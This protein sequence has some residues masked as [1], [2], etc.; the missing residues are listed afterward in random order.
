MRVYISST[1]LDLETE[2]RVVMDWLIAQDHQPVHSYVADSET[3]RDSCLA[4]IDRCDLYILLLCHRYGSRPIKNNPENLSITHLEFRRAGDKKIPR[5]ALL[6]TAIPNVV[7]S[8]IGDPSDL[9]A[10][11]KFRDEVCHELRPAEFNDGAS[12]LAGLSNAVGAFLRKNNT[13]AEADTRSTPSDWRWPYAWDFSAYIASKRLNF[14]GR[15]WLFKEIDAWLCNSTP[16]DLLLRADFGVGKTAFASELIRRDRMRGAQDRLVVAIHFCQ[17]DTRET[18]RASTFVRSVAAQLAENV[19]GYKALVESSPTAQQQLDR[20]AEDPGSAFEAAILNPLI[21]MAPFRH[22]AV[23]LVDAIDESLELEAAEAKRGT[24]VQLLADKAP[25]LPTWIRLLVTSRNNPAV[26]DRLKFAFGPKE[27]DGEALLNLDDIRVYVLRRCTTEPIASKLATGDTSAND[28]ADRLCRK[29]GGKFLYAVRVLD[30]LSAGRLSSIELE[31]LPT[32]M[33][34]FY[35]DAFERRF[36]RAGRDYVEVAKLFGI[37]VASREPMSPDLL[38]LVLSIGE[39]KL[40]ALRVEALSDFIR[41]RDGHWVFDHSSL[42]EW[43]C[44]DD[45]EGNA[46]AGRYGVDLVASRAALA[47]WATGIYEAGLDNVHVHVLRHLPG[48]LSDSG[49]AARVQGL[50][51]DL[52]W[53]QIKLSQLGP[54]ELLTDFNFA[55][56]DQTTMLLAKT[57]DMCAHIFVKDPHQLCGQLLGRLRAE[58]AP[59]LSKLLDACRDW[60]A[61][62]WLRPLTSSLTPPGNLIRV[63]QG[64]SDILQ[65]G[66]FSPD[67]KFLLSASAD[68]IARLW[69]VSGETLATLDAKAGSMNHAI[70]SHDGELI[71][72]TYEDKHARLWTRTGSLLLVFETPASSIRAAF[73][74]DNELVLVTCGDKVAR[75]WRKNGDFVATLRGHERRVVDGGF[76][77]NGTLIATASSDGTARLWNSEGRFVAELRGHTGMVVRATF[78]PDGTLVVTASLDHTSKIWD[79]GGNLLR[80]LNGHLGAINH[81]AFSPNGE[82]IAT[83]SNDNTARIWNVNGELLGVLR[84]HTGWVNHLS[85]STDSQNVVT[86][87]CD[88]T[89]RLWRTNGELLS[90]FRGHSGWIVQ[91]AFSPNGELIMTCANDG[92]MRLWNNASA[93]LSPVVVH[94]D[95]VTSIAVNGDASTVLSTSNDHNSVLWNRLGETLFTLRGH[96][97]GVTFGEFFADGHRIVTASCDGTARVWK[98]SDDSLVLAGHSASVNYATSSPDGGLVATASN[99]CTAKL[100]LSTGEL[101]ATLTGHI[102]AVNHVTFSSDGEI[103]ATSSNDTTVR[104]WKKDGSLCGVLK[105]HSGWVNQSSFS[106]DGAMLVSCSED[107]SSCVW[108]PDGTQLAVLRGHTDAV[109]CVRI[110]SN[111]RLIVTASRD[112]T[113]RLWRATGELVWVGEKHTELVTNAVFASDDHTVISCA[114]DCTVRVWRAGRSV[115]SLN[116]DAPIVALAVVHGLIVCGDTL[117]GVHFLEI[118]EPA[119]NV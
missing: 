8:S 75:L 33:D 87:S 4:D 7:H 26:T 76:S 97:Q 105:G 13:V 81:V 90:V 30:D 34:A 16:R 92:T 61:N 11:L 9:S 29:S 23:I 79:V 80:T 42:R 63:Y 22:T 98:R 100:W 18:L 24:L 5:I 91:T 85:F 111:G 1:K 95:R 36:D 12:L 27:I 68:G 93:N 71:V 107:G 67:G 56:S 101:H 119:R 77:P 118:V 65:S 66:S 62:P 55:P 46:R 58:M 112:N 48:Y 115:A 59:G 114:E 64:H 54:Y 52:R 103:I 113:V 108:R 40:K 2:R 88:N 50:L 39:R 19:P 44:S 102:D 86:G 45:A 96:Q 10:I 31:H 83:A 49:R 25:R 70:F 35:F 6:R 84:G 17:H 37:M 15:D 38:A 43:L 51:L 78:S 28:V 72:T 47:D 109:V 14:I 41:V 73:S 82:M 32:G 117:G 94:S 21:G 60:F 3:V 106:S 89:A 20:A 74:P 53:L 110:S 104:I 99:D 57:F 116:V 69:R